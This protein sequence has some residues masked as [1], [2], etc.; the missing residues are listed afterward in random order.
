[1]RALWVEDHVLIGDSLETLLQVVMP[2]VSLDKARDLKTAMALVSA[3][4]YDLVLL[5][6]WLGPNTGEQAMARFREVGCLAPFLVVSGDERE[7]V[8][9]RAL[10]LGAVG[11]VSK[12]SPPHALV[13]TMRS[14][15]SGKA[16]GAADAALV[17]TTAAPQRPNVSLGTLFPELTERQLDVFEQ[18]TLGRSDKQI[19]RHLGVA[20]ST[21]R[22]H[23][24]AILEIVGVHSRGEATHAAQV[25][26][27][28]AF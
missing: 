1:M 10:A 11:F 21:V 9:S 6:W 19:A 20:S 22:T 12:A 8:K 16:S 5:D 25:R 3:I 28:G 27:A 26:G 15:L 2:E 18:L 7:V 14:A 13:E 4:P 24:R 23:V 17:A